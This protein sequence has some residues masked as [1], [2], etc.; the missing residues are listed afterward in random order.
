MFR[1]SANEPDTIVSQVKS[2]GFKA[3]AIIVVGN[4]VQLR[5]SLRWFEDRPLFGKRIVVTRARE[6]A[7]ELADTL[8]ALGAE[9]L[10]CPTIKIVPVD[11]PAPL[12]RAIHTISDYEWLIFTSVNGVD[13]FFKRLFDNQRDVRALHS[14]KIAAVGPATSK[15]LFDFGLT[16]DILPKDYRAESIVE[17]FSGMNIKD[18][19]ILL[20]RARDAGSVLPVELTKM[21]AII[22]DIAVYTNTADQENANLLLSRLKESTIDLITF[23]SSS[24]VKNFKALLPPA[25]FQELIGGVTIACI[26]PIT[27]ETAKDLGFDVQ[28]I[29]ETSTIPGLCDAIQRHYSVA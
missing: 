2:T 14:L 16:S 18:K 20:P 12:D 28:V 29:A 13:F 9:C 15:R 17:A 24:T 4:V 5:E 21:G 6:Q 19:K 11:D 3:P 25:R 22:D 26:G 27:A 8:R 7:G 1:I 23:T 10:E